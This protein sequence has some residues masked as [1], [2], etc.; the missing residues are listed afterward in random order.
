M[1]FLEKQLTVN[2][3]GL[4]EAGLGLFTNIFI[5]KGTRIAE[6]KG[7]VTSWKLVSQSVDNPYIF[8]ITRNHVIDAQGYKKAL[9]RYA[10]DAQGLHRIKGIKNNSM[11]VIEDNRVFIE[12]ITDIPAMSEIFVS[13]GK[14]YWDTIR[15]NAKH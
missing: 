10:N 1:A 4:P 13:Y 5:P 9:A 15:F 11:Y 7:H 14:E 12:A 8:Y 3:S 6:Y 2:T